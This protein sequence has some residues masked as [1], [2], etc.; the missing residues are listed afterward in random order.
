VC[1]KF[2]ISV[3]LLDATP[4]WSFPPLSNNNMADA[5]VCEVG[6]VLKLLDTDSSANRKLLIAFMTS[7]S[8]VYE[9]SE[10]GGGTIIRN[11]GNYRCHDV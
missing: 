7:C 5:Q 6:A 1:T 2:S 11:V 10:D 4:K 9:Y 3:M 8:L